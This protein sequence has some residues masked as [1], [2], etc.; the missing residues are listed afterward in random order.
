MAEALARH[1]WP[2]DAVVQSA[3]SRPSNV[4]PYAL[5]VLAELGIDA[6]TQRSKGME[7]IV[8]DTVDTVVTLCVEEVCPAFPRPV[9]RLAWPVPDPAATTGEE[10]DRLSA[11]RAVRDDLHRRVLEFRAQEFPD[12][13]EP[14]EASQEE[15]R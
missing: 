6:S 5:R 15:K 2:S 10:D 7:A 9:R 4:N 1:V 11:F 8:L 3:G 13:V 14:P 12:V